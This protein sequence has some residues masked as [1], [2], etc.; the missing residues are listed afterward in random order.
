MLERGQKVWIQSG[1]SGDSLC[2]RRLPSQRDSE[3]KLAC[4]DLASLLLSGTAS[5]SLQRG[6]INSS[7]KT[8]TE[9]TQ[10]WEEKAN[11]T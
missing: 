11:L 9:D 8:R 10:M 6:G 3:A 2:L 1:F 7:T 5:S 4:G